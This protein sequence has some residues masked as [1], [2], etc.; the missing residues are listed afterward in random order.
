MKKGPFRSP[1]GV[2]PFI[3]DRLNFTPPLEEGYTVSPGKGRYLHVVRACLS[4]ERLA[5]LFT[6]YTESLFPKSCYGILEWSGHGTTEDTAGDGRPKGVK[7]YLTAFQDTK[8]FLKG[9]E[10]YLFRLIN[11]GMVAFGA[12][13]YDESRLEEI[14]ISEKKAVLCYTSDLEGVKQ[15]LG[16]FQVEPRENLRFLSEWQTLVG[17]LQ[18]LSK[19]GKEY[20]S[21]SADEYN[22]SIYIPELVKALGF[23]EQI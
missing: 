19:I 12:A 3:E 8:R 1:L 10:P 11:D 16:R 13:W 9:I 5:P 18:T 7:T 17:D 2:V 21:F 15:I 4:A 14:F 20:Q 6:A 23:S 22:P